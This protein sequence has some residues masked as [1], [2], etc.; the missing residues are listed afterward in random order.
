MQFSTLILFEI[1]NIKNKLNDKELILSG[2]GTIS[3]PKQ[4][5]R[6]KILS[7]RDQSN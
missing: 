1:T 5:T 7:S 3:Q 2:I 4:Y 6:N